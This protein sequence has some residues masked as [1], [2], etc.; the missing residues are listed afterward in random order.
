MLNLITS[1]LKQQFCK[2][3]SRLS[4]SKQN[5]GIY[6]RSFKAKVTKLRFHP[7]GI[8]IPA[9]EMQLLDLVGKDLW[10]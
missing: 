6:Y 2:E 7:F 3:I 4:I 1:S 5:S 10:K 9:F 8:E